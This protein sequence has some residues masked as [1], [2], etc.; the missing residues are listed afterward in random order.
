M[1]EE[2]GLNLGMVR[3]V[4]RIIVTHDLVNIFHVPFQMIWLRIAL[5]TQLASI[6][7]FFGVN[8]S[9]SLQIGTFK[10]TF[11]TDSTLITS[12]FYIWD[13]LKLRMRLWKNLNWTDKLFLSFFQTEFIWFYK[14]C[15]L[16]DIYCFIKVRHYRKFN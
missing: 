4:R 12:W 11:E 5:I 7:F 8:N 13:T 10:K 9:V 3:T 6:R 15:I 16:L 1:S 2:T 14:N